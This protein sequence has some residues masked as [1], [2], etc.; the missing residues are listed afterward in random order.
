MP[1]CRPVSGHAR[2][3]AVD[4]DHQCIAAEFGS[5]DL[6]TLDESAKSAILDRIK[7][8]LNIP[9]FTRRDL[10]YVGPN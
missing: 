4:R 2:C 1:S 8:I 5:V 7:T 10:G 6:S 3:S 9:T